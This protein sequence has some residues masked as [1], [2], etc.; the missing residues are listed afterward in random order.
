[1]V[2][3]VVEVVGVALVATLVMGGLLT[4]VAPCRVTWPRRETVL[5]VRRHRRSE[6]RQLTHRG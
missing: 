6:R 3:E 4:Q 5:D 2:V 1:M